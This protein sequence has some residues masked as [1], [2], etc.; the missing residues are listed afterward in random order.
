MVGGGG[1]IPHNKYRSSTL[2]GIRHPEMALQAAFRTGSNFEACNDLLQTGDAYSAEEK[3]RSRA[4]LLI[5]L[6][7]V[8]PASWLKSPIIIQS[9]LLTSVIAVNIFSLSCLVMFVRRCSTP[10][11]TVVCTVTNLPVRTSLDSD[12]IQDILM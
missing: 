1:V 4:V 7:F 10:M 8:P 6:A 5:V 11:V 9:P 2:V 3:H 12:R